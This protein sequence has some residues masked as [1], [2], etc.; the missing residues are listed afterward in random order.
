MGKIPDLTTDVTG[1]ATQ[2]IGAAAG[3]S[4]GGFATRHVGDADGTELHLISPGEASGIFR[5]YCD[6]LT[7]IQGDTSRCFQGLVNIK[8]TVGFLFLSLKCNIC[9]DVFKTWR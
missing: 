3:T 6:K 2:P 8:T 9:S 1:D 7:H 5:K 4:A